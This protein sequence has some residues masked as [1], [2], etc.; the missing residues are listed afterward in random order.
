MDN[1][2]HKLS[3]LTTNKT[4]IFY[5][6]ISEPGETLVRTGTIGE[7]SCLFHS[8]LHACSKE[9]V[10]YD[11]TERMEYVK[12]L[13]ANMARQIDKKGWEEIGNGTISKLPFQE[14]VNMFIKNI[15]KFLKSKKYRSTNKNIK[16][17][18]EILIGDDNT[19]KEAYAV[20]TEL[21][22]FKKGFEHNI[23]PK[24]YKQCEDR[25][26][27]DCKGVIKT[28][29]LKYIAKYAASLIETLSD[30]QLVQIKKMVDIFLDVIMDEAEHF[31]YKTYIHTLKTV[32][33]EIDQQ[34]IDVISNKFDIDIYFIDCS[35]RMPY[36]NASSENNLKKRKSVIVLWIN[37]NHY[38]I[39]GKLLTE[40]R[41]QREF[42][43]DDPLI[44]KLYMFLREPENV[45]K[46]YPDI[47][48]YVPRKYMLDAL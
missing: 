17:I 46:T 26:I 1:E 29:S 7:G 23:L 30:K 40:N 37:E 47:S 24:S 33:E 5:S 38:E 48:S 36:Q 10:E 34:T 21:I 18:I 2:I 44:K 3:Q 20:L 14:N 4:V 31:A 28:E 25:K 22:P 8:I 6:P 11:I 43:P 9:Y 32:S 19:K 12:N 35:T 39:I 27:Q 15:Y 41:V 45:C 42:R 13:R 16:N